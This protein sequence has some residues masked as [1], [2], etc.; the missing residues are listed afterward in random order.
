MRWISGLGLALGLAAC[1]GG[2]PST[3]VKMIVSDAPPAYGDTPFPT[4]AL[5]DGDHLGLVT[6]LDS[7]I[8]SHIDLVASHVA[9]LDGFGL[10]PVIEFFVDG[11]FDPA[12]LPATTTALTDPLAVVDPATGEVIAM[13][14]RYDA[15]RASIVGAPV[16]GAQLREGTPYAAVITTDLVGRAP[17]LDAL[18]TAA[19]ARWQSTA[20]ATA[21]LATMPAL[22]GRI[23][24]VAAFT[25]EHATAPLALARAVEIDPAQVPAPTL[26]FAD[27]A[28]IFK[29]KAR[30]DALLGVATR[31][32]DGPRAGLE[33]WGNDNPTGIAHDHVGVIATGTMTIARFRA[34]DTGTDGPEDESFQLDPETGAPRVIAVDT[35]PVTF[36]L[37]AAAPPADGYPLIVLGHGLGGSRQHLLAF[38]EPLCSQGY[39]L[40]I[41]DMAG[42]GSRFDPTDN[43]NNLADQI[44]DDFTGDPALRDGLG[45]FTGAVTQ[46]DFFEKFLNVTALRDGIRQSALDI[47]RLTD[48]LRRPDLDLSALARNGHTPTLDTRHVAYLGESF[49]TVV[50]TLLAAIE[51]DIDLYVL[52][53]PGGGILD[54]LLPGSPAIGGPALPVIEALYRPRGGIDRFSPMIG[55]MQAVLDG[56]DPLAYARHITRDRFTIA[57]ETLGPRSVVCLEVVG[58]E[59]LS[60][61]GTSALAIGLGVSALAPHL[62]IP[63][64]MPEVASPASANLDGQTAIL[65]QYSPATHGANWSSEHGELHF[66][67][68]FPVAGLDPFPQLPAPITIDNPIYATFDQVYDLLA[69]HQAGAAPVVRST[70]AP[71][72]DFDDDGTPD[73]DDPAPLDPTR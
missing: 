51:Q 64:G 72:H 26:A 38:A 36:A 63:P 53:V 7:M 28:I 30:L 10:R 19:P 1:D 21:A 59:V 4:D 5:R 52:D 58:D 66:M 25:T 71:V 70:L 31:A 60:N 13:D 34:D 22:A 16:L 12:T 43:H 69:S 20:D 29:G 56:G 18:A 40:A 67:P 62:E 24:G 50:G 46:L 41:I 54:L 17:A 6:G 48:L 57:G 2:G 65:V 45:D 42:H 35:I 68:G 33:R 3:T 49:G 27:P 73:A 39:A 44:G 9:A 47:A 61:T 23:A 8:A 37:P 32:T 55:L 15:D 14:W 11:D